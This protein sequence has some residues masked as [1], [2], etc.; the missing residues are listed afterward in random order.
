MNQG[1]MIGNGG[2]GVVGWGLEVEAILTWQRIKRE[3]KRESYGAHYIRIDFV[4][5]L[6][7]NENKKTNCWAFQS[8]CMYVR[9][10][11]CVSV[12]M[13]VRWWCMCKCN[14]FIHVCTCTE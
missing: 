5:F 1:N 6:K 12:C 14:Q 4:H 2:G 10:C 7:K 13:Y 8:S 11:M 9:V 3:K